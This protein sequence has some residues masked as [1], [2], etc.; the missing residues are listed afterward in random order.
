MRSNRPSD[1]V[2]PRLVTVGRQDGAQKGFRFVHEAAQ[3]GAGAV[4]F[5]HGE[6][7]RVGGGA[8]LVAPDAGEL[9]DRAGAAGEQFLHREFRA[10]VQP[11]RKLFAANRVELG[12]EGFQVHLLAGGLDGV[13]R[14]DLGV[15]A[16]GEEGA[17]GGGEQRTAAQKG[18]ARCEALRMP[19]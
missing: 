18:Q 11:E 10:G 16:R 4:P 8:F 19:P 6:F 9:E 13:G 1:V 5:E 17:C 7:R 2:T 15:A 3:R 14:F 12:G